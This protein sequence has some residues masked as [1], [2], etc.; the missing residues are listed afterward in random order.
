DK[1]F[2]DGIENR[3]HLRDV[4]GGFLEA[5]NIFNFGEALHRARLDVHAG[6]ALHAVKNDGQGHGFGDGAIVLEEALL[7]GFVVIRSDR[8]NAVGSKSGELLRE[9]DD[10]GSVIAAG[11]PEDRHLTAS[12]FDGDLN[13]AKMLFVRE[14]GALAGGSTG[15]EEVNA[16]L[17]LSLDQSSQGGFVKRTILTKRCDQCGACA[18]KHGCCSFLFSLS[19]IR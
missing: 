5:D 13:D 11:A 7:G 9:S 8:E 4:T 16:C 18:C 19:P 17:D 14:R 10:F 6:A 2:R 3:S 12:Q 15:N 1:A